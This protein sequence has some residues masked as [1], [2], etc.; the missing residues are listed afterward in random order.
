VDLQPDHTNY[1][2]Y[3]AVLEGVLF[4]IYQCYEVLT[5]VGK[6]PE[7]VK[8][9]GGILESPYWTQMAADIFGRSIE[10]DP[11]QNA[12]LVGAATVAME[13]LG[14]INDLS[15]MELPTAK[16]VHPNP[17]KR[18]LYSNRYKRYQYWYERST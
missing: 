10:I 13:K 17:D 2:L 1:D 18:E 14:V 3:H 7:R 16:T 9:S 4:N 15:D 8:L 6:I 5:K 12:S 11:A